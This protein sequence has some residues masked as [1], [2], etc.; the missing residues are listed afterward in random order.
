MASFTWPAGIAIG[1]ARIAPGEPIT[2]D[3]MTDYR[4]RDDYIQ[5]LFDDA[6]GHHHAGAGQGRPIQPGGLGA[7]CVGNVQIANGEVIYGKLG[8]NAAHAAEINANAVGVAEISFVAPGA[9]SGT[10]DHTMTGGTVCHYPQVKTGGAGT[11]AA[12]IANAVAS[13]AYV[14][15]IY[16][17]PSVSGSAQWWYVGTGV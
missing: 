10:G 8:P 4:D 5:G 15:N 12:A 1:D 2:S 7:N 17:N 16:L 6:A 14:T 13:G 3:L 11:I 9:V